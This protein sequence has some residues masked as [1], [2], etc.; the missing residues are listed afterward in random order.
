MAWWPDRIPFRLRIFFRGAFLLLT[1]ATV[2]LVLS[3]LREEK[4]QSYRSYS[5]VF[6]KNVE[7]IAAKL[8]HPTG[9]LALLNPASVGDTGA[10]LRPLLLPFAAIDFDDKA[11]AQQAVEMAGCLVQYPDHAQLCVAVGN[12]PFLGGFIYTVGEF[13]GGTLVEHQRGETDLTLAHRLRVEVV[14]RGETYRWI[15]PL[16]SAVPTRSAS[17]QGRLTG[18]AEDEQG[19]PAKRPN[20]EFRGWLWQDSR[21]LE[22]A[23]AETTP[24][25]CRRRTFFSVRLPVALINEALLKSPRLEWPPAD[26]AQIK[27][28][29]QVYAPGTGK[30]LFDSDEF[31]ATVPFA[32]T[33]LRAQLP[34]GETL[35][36]RKA[37]ATADLVSLRGV[38]DD[39]T[40]PSL[41]LSRLVGWL[42]IEDASKPL[43]DSRVVSTAMGDYELHVIGDTRSVDRNIGRVAARMLWFVTAMLVAI[44]ITWLAIEARII[45]RITLLTRRA[46]AVKKS[47]HG[48]EGLALDLSDLQGRDELGLLASVLAQLLQRINEDAKREQI[49]ADQ[50]KD[51]LHAVGHEILSPLQSLLALHEAPNDP[52]L[53]YIRRMQQAVRLLYGSATPTEAILSAALQVSTL[54]VEAFLRHVADNAIHAG[55]RNVQFESS[56]GPLIVKADAYSLEDVITH[57]LTNA[58]RYR[59]PGTPVRITLQRTAT[60]VQVHLYNQGPRIPDG[61]LNR[62]FEYGVSDAGD[63]NHGN[64]G[65]GLFVARTY[66]AKMGGTIEAHNLP[67]GVEIVLSLAIAD[68]P[69]FTR[70]G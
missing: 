40:R 52:S 44:L 31:G 68:H 62:I 24:E 35:T 11:K 64:R 7:Q 2:A 18:F 63:S 12:N 38:E 36:I 4:Q 34:A 60:A 6:H 43:A 57:V 55:I 61:L 45:R 3:E 9:Q 49:R 46:A 51:L 69:A 65:Q 32:L 8:R 30:P 41:L 21:C 27:V 33:D 26:L 16:E 22:E 15:A 1:L 54:D 66:M 28:H 39:S 10:A 23:A 42:P 37:G 19:Q 13:A 67:E 17:V 20:R 47:V 5:E 53:R 59:L 29:L 14:M 48:S 70:G 58:D 56:A 25:E 50:E